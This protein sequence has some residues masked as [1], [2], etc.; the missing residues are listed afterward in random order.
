[1]PFQVTIKP[2]NHQYQAQEHETLLESGLREGFALPYGCRNGACGACKGKIVEGRVDY[3]A[4]QENALSENEKH[5]GM[6]LF[7]TAKP[8]TDVVIECREVG[9]ARDIPIKTMPCRV[10]KMEKLSH[11]VMVLYLKLPANERLQFL[12]GQYID[13]LLKDGKRRSFSLANAPHDD[14]FLQL[15]IRHIPG[16]LFTDVVFNSMQEKAI[17]RFEGPYGSFFLREDSDKPIIFMAGG[18]GFAPVKA[19]VEHALQAHCKRE[20]V[21]YWG[22]RSLRDL[23]MPQLAGKWQQENPNFTFI[24]VLSEPLPEDN[25]PGRTGLVHQA[26][27]DDFANLSGYQVYACGAPQMVE[28]GQQAFVA[29]G[30]P[31]EE[32]F[33]DPFTFSAGG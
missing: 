6:A 21:L 26:I 33:V 2:S 15:H 4:Y 8:L 23:Y 11:D 7:C 29:R 14:E 25:W 10:Q 3:G 30:L 27:L 1:M 17:L 31:E 12:A 13:I 32:Y 22:A 16:G 20:M 9:A 18:T 5:A 28:A 24:P 19:I